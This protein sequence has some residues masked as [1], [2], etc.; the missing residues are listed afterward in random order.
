MRW[1]KVIFAGCSG[2]TLFHAAPASDVTM[3]P[4]FEGMTVELGVCAVVKL[5]SRAFCAHTDAGYDAGRTA[6]GAW[7][8]VAAEE[9]FFGRSFLRAAPTSWGCH[10]EFDWKTESKT[11]VEWRVAVS[12]TGV[13]VASLGVGQYDWQTEGLGV[14]Q[15]DGHGFADPYKFSGRGFSSTTSGWSMWTCLKPGRF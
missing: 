4:A 2:R 12:T 7:Q 9:K 8:P 14:L 10:G 15:G 5:C 13:A 6:R 3:M 1:L 11:K